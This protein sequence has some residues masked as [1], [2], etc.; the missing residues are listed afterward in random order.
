MELQAAT[1]YFFCRQG[2]T[3]L[4]DFVKKVQEIVDRMKIEENPRDKTMRNLLLVGL[5]SPE[6][7][8]EC[9]KEDIKK[10]DSKKVIQIAERIES[11]N[12][13]KTALRKT[14]TQTLPQTAM[15]QGKSPPETSDVNKLKTKWKSN[16]KT[17]PAPKKF[18][19]QKLKQCRWCGQK[20]FCK[21]EECPAK[22]RICNFC[23]K[24]G[25]FEKVC[26]KKMVKDV[27]EVQAEEE[28]P[29]A[30]YYYLG[31]ISSHQKTQNHLRPIWISKTSTSSI[32]N[33]DAEVDTGSD[34]SVLPEYIF[35]EI[36]GDIPME[37]ATVEM[38]AYGNFIIPVIGSTKMIIHT[39]EGEVTERFQI[40][41]EKKHLILGRELSEKIKYVTFPPIT[42]PE[43]DQEPK[44]LKIHQVKKTEEPEVKVPQVK[45]NSE[46]KE[47]T[48][49]GQ[50]WKLPVTK[51]Q[52]QQDFK[53]V[54]TGLGTLPGGPY[55]LKLKPGA[56]PVQHPPRRVP[57]KKKE[58][59]KAELTRLQNLKVIEKVEGHT[60]WINSIVPADKPDGSL[61]LCLDPRDLNEA[62]QRNPYHMK[63][64]DEISAELYG[65]EWFTL[66][67]ASSG[68][69]HVPLDEKSSYL[70]TFNT[71]WGK[72]RF[73]RLPFGLK[74]SS[75]VF[76]QRL[77][78]VLTKLHNVTGMADDCLAK[79]RT[80]E[81]H[82]VAI[83]TLLQAARLNG[84]KFNSKK[85]QFKT[86]KCSFFGQLLT[87]EGFKQDP[88]K[89]WKHPKTEQ[90]WNPS[91]AWSTT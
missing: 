35:K 19:E 6:I 77:E 18:E 60:D 14:A 16:Q 12:R 64:M 44:K 89:I 52:I 46:K 57:E 50:T 11:D 36:C 65:A 30:E 45:Y 66:V 85:I 81:E 8:A 29:D 61:R 34:T 49:E 41:K 4:T 84:I 15:M 5:T 13:F 90:L 67:D 21:K 70:T 17:K 75:D 37:A 10:L 72:Y 82:D 38:R 28:V 83:L 76:Q 87:P 25:H 24:K 40:T 47:V 86:K 23:K 62:L 71:P 51:D 68:F 22:D 78:A 2:E 54:F 56:E 79:G 55:Q 7:Y 27:H 42:P 20:K 69:W 91:W 74:T 33:F 48:I 59:Y 80:E 58:A 26:R 88:K 73:L 53:D 39:S 9:C 31:S 63:T 3:T 43:L 1:E 32:F